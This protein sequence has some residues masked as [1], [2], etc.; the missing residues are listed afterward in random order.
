MSQGE[1]EQPP[2]VVIAPLGRRLFA[3]LGGAIAWTL[4]FL[5][6]YAVIAIGC[7]AG[8]APTARLVV[9]VG[10]V[11]FAGVAAWS[12]LIAWHEWRRVSGGQRWDEALNEPRGW[13][14]WLMLIGVLM[15][16]TSILTIVLEGSGSLLLPACGWNAR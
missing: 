8:W 2:G 12:T 13:Y 15:G 10:T 16:L 14:P 5:G 7:V 6:S 11:L 9:A 4:H 3:I 1:T